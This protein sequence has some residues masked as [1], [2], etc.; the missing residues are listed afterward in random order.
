MPPESTESYARDRLGNSYPELD[1]LRAQEGMVGG[2]N[3][4]GITVIGS[5]D[6]GNDLTVVSK[7]THADEM[8]LTQIHVFNSDSIN[9]T[10][11]L[12]EGSATSGGS[13]ASATRRSVNY[14]VN[15]QVS[16]TIDIQGK[17]YEQSIGVNSDF[18]GQIGVAY[19]SDHKESSE[20]V[21]Y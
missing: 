11:H 16:R 9:S 5:A 3:G 4:E 18:Q 15:S 21:T 19:I 14:N 12:V 7:P 2:G 13:I 6:T 10:F 8:I 1:N 20:S 17:P